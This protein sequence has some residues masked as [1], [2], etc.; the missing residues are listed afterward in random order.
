MTDQYTLQ[1][2]SRPSYLR[3]PAWRWQLALHS[4]LDSG[5]SDIY[6]TED[7]WLIEACTFYNSLVGGMKA[8]W[9]KS[10]YPEMYEAW[11]LNQ[12]V[13]PQCGLK[14]VLDGMLMTPENDATIAQVFPQFWHGAKTVEC[15]RR[16]FFDIAEFQ[17]ND[18][19]LLNNLLAISI[20]STEWSDNDFVYK[21][22]AKHNGF[23]LFLEL[24][25]FKTG[26]TLNPRIEAYIHRAIQDRRKWVMYEKVVDL[27]RT[28]RHDAE[29]LA[30]ALGERFDF[31]V[32]TDSNDP[33]SA[34][35]KSSIAILQKVE[36]H[37]NEWANRRQVP[38]QKLISER[39]TIE[40][41]TA[42]ADYR[43]QNKPK[44]LES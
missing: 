29:T 11:Q 16:V 26:G 6:A 36:E 15:F 4:I 43:E 39:C 42:D 19:L 18:A 32:N 28:V 27:Q 41:M 5:M 2:L 24:I 3:H 33:K 22:F 21:I 9:L 7:P 20:P 25:S 35:G 37:F 23:E 44:A 38:V 17:N 34:M 13:H 30:I 8:L 1:Q 12:Q 40:G 10:R 31:Q 14:W